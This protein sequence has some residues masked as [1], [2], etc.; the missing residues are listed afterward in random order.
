MNYLF[1]PK[2]LSSTTQRHQC[3]AWSALRQFVFG[4]D[5]MAWHDEKTDADRVSQALLFLFRPSPPDSILGRATSSSS[6]TRTCTCW[7]A[8]VAQAARAAISGAGD[9]GA[10]TPLTSPPPPR[11]QAGASAAAAAAA[12]TRAGADKL[13]EEDEEEWEG[14]EAEFAAAFGAEVEGALGTLLE[15]VS[16]GMPAAAAFERRDPVNGARACVCV[17]W[18]G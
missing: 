14:E 5:G 1:F 12:A 8:R 11:P 7:H 15:Q 17:S 2:S 10:G 16:F 6:A 3:Q 4:N 9:S 13:E 18:Q